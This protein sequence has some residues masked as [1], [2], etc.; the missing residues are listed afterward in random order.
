MFGIIWVWPP[1]AKGGGT[2]MKLTFDFNLQE[3]LIIFCLL[4]A[5]LRQ[6]RP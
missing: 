5:H 1:P 6:N 3:I 2:Y 4:A